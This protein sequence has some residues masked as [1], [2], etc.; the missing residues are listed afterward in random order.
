MGNSVN[1]GMGNE[2]PFNQYTIIIISQSIKMEIEEKKVTLDDLTT[3]MRSTKAKWQRLSS[4]ELN[5]LL[6]L[7]K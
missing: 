2:A 5:R 7:C 6:L 1:P 4:I 3:S